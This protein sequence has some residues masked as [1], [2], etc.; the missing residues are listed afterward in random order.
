MIDLVYEKG[1][2][3]ALAKTGDDNRSCTYVFPSYDAFLARS[4]K[5]LNG[6]S[7]AFAKKHPN[8]VEDNRSNEGCWECVGCKGC[9]RCMR[10]VDCYRCSGCVDIRVCTMC[11][12]CGDMYNCESCSNCNWLRD[13]NDCVS[14]YRCEDCSHLVGAEDLSGVHLEPRGWLGQD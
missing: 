14:S 13:S 12:D 3:D 4:D 2:L 5:S 7:E 9:Y 11:I 8:Y 1:L 6:V 10:S